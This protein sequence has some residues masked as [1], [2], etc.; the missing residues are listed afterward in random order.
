MLR[1][2]STRIKA[3]QNKVKMNGTQLLCASLGGRR[4]KVTAADDI[5]ELRIMPLSMETA[6]VGGVKN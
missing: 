6:K 2:W 4:R 5:R 3:A 1:Y